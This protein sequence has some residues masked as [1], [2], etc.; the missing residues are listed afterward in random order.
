[1]SKNG[2]KNDD[3]MT[4]PEWI[5]KGELKTTVHRPIVAEPCT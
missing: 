2:Q 5:E 3:D 1:M 4:V